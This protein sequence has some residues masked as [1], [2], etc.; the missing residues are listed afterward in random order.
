MPETVKICLY[1][2]R[3]PCIS[4]PS[5]CLPITSRDLVKERANACGAGNIALSPIMIEDRRASG[6]PDPIATLRKGN[7]CSAYQQPALMPDPSRSPAEDDEPQWFPRSSALEPAPPAASA[8]I[9]IPDMAVDRLALQAA[10]QPLCFAPC[11]HP[12]EIMS[13]A[14]G[15]TATAFSRKA[16]LPGLAYGHLSA[17]ACSGRA[18]CLAVPDSVF[19]NDPSCPI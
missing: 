3:S 1:C 9:M 4:Q 15:R 16:L 14:K 8:A 11:R 17:A 12:L 7:W 19:I 10:P 5:F 13:S 6:M 18:A 2:S